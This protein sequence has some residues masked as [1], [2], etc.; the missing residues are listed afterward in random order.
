MVSLNAGFPNGD[1]G[2]K[3]WGFQPG[4]GGADSVTGTY[5]GTAS[6]VSFEFDRTPDAATEGDLL[7]GDLLFPADA[8]NGDHTDFADHIYYRAVTPTPAGRSMPTIN[9]GG[10]VNAASFAST[11]APGSWVSIL[12][13]GFAA[14]ARPWNS[15][16]FQNGAAPTQLD[17]TS[18]LINGQPAFVGYISPTQVN[19][20][21]P[22][23]TAAGPIQVTVSVY[24]QAGW[25]APAQM[26][27][28]SPA[29]FLWQGQ[30][31]AAQHAD[32]THV[33][34]PGLLPGVNTT[35]ALQGETIILYG[36]G[37]GPSEPAVPAG[38]ASEKA[39]P[40]AN[41]V[42][43]QVGGIDAQV[44]FAGLAQGFVGLDQINVIIPDTAPDGDLPVVLTVGGK[45][46]TPALV[47]VQRGP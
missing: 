11:I 32:Y 6:P 8:A 12:G 33:G 14:N 36:T 35:P 22:D 7:F 9:S 16:D 46:T 44:A 37:F 3:P 45:T 40:L 29:L 21:A 23:D 34:K 25:A 42:T 26:E 30:F 38:I 27:S 17:G 18:V 4:K 24:G 5:L 10:V 20:Q 19:V 39:V 13:T 41:R 15:S 31:A 28:F 1:P 47:T 2:Q 43:A